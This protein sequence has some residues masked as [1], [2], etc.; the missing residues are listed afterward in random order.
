M[1]ADLDV[2]LLRAFV[3]TIRAGS[4][5]RAASA[6]GHTQ[7]GVSQQLRRLE[8]AVGQQLLHRASSG[9]SPTRAGE[10]LM[11]YAE[12]IIA[13]SA[14]ALA[15]TSEA[16][17]GHCGIGILED[18]AVARI[19][20]LLADFARLHPEVTLEVMI[21]S[22]PRIRDALD[23]RRIQLALTDVGY[24][25]ES[26]RWSVRHPLVWVSGP[27]IDLQA[28]PLPLVLFS[29]PCRWRT[30]LLEALDQAGR[31]WRVTFESTGLAGVHAAVRAG[32]GVSAFLPANV[33]T[34]LM[35]VPA[36]ILPPLPD[37]EL[38][39]VRR[40]GTQGDPLVDAVELALQAM[41]R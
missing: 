6:L 26:P 1:G 18:L 24:L 2:V 31:H 5:S 35:V 25:S 4:I 34:D 39:L 22:G 36:P 14:Q 23:E 20:Q 33:S 41:M 17:T 38:G 13:L 15:S 19:P 10:A 8:R 12:R 37:I 21:L 3:T 7:P 9:V 30:A 29:Q 40:P 32:L 27:D 28:D 11:P 16:L